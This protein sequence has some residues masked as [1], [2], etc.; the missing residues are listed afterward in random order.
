MERVPE[1][2]L[3]EDDAQAEAYARADFEEPNSYFVEQVAERFDALPAEA[4]VL[5][6]G[7]G[8]ADIAVRLAKRYPGWRVEAVDG[9]AAML[10]HARVAVDA[11]GL[12]DRVELVHATIPHPPLVERRYDVVLSN[13]LLHHLHDP[14]VLWELVAQVAEP[15][16]AILIMDLCRPP[17]MATVRALVE[18]HSAGEP[19]VLRRDFLNSLRAAFT[20]AEIEAQLAAAALGEL[21]VER[22]SDRHLLV[23]G[24]RRRPAS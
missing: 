18:E 17:D 23:H 15:G 20:P 21:A 14:S 13:S 10:A 3:M 24:R 2:E 1:P 8:P 6:L 16:A 12:G 11:A 22:V 7:C 19:E 5:D 9:S 4:R